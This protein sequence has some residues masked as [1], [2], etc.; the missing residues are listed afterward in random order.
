MTPQ[1]ARQE[2][3]GVAFLEAPLSTSLAQAM[4]YRQTC[5]QQLTLL[6][7]MYVLGRKERFN[8]CP[9]FGRRWQS[10]WGPM[11]CMISDDDGLGRPHTQP[12]VYP[13]LARTLNQRYLRYTREWFNAG[14]G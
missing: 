12:Q 4:S 3:C 9:R 2:R 5:P 13:D 10:T 6:R 8:S 11:M 7:D 14:E 1:K